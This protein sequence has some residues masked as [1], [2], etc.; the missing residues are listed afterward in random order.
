MFF[1][2][3]VWNAAGDVPLIQTPTVTNTD[4]QGTVTA[5]GAEWHYVS[6]KQYLVTWDT[7][8][9]DVQIKVRLTDAYRIPTIISTY[10]LLMLIILR[11]FSGPYIS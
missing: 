1:F 11:T 9:E 7:L 2:Q 6:N 3:E 5:A 4:L 8:S 10:R